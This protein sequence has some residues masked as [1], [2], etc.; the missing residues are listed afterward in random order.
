MRGRLMEA[1]ESWRVNERRRDAE[2]RLDRV[3]RSALELREDKEE[4]TDRLRAG[5]AITWVIVSAMALLA[6]QGDVEKLKDP[7]QLSARAPDRFRARFDTSQGVFVIAVEGVGTARRRPF[8]QSREERLLQRHAFLPGPR[9]LHGAVWPARRSGR[10]GSVEIRE[11]ERR[12]GGQEQH[13]RV[14]DLHDRVAPGLALHDDLHQLQGQQ[15]PGCRRLCALWAGR[16][17]HR[18]VDRLCRG[19]GRQTARISSAF[20]ERAMRICSP[21]TETGFCE[22]RDNRR[23]CSARR[24]TEAREPHA[25]G[26]ASSSGKSSTPRTNNSSGNAPRI[27]IEPFTTVFGTP[28]TRKRRERSRNSVAST[29]E[30]WIKAFSGASRCASDTARG[31][32][33]HVGVTKTWMSR[34]AVTYAAIS[35]RLPVSSCESFV[36]ARISA[37]MN[38][39]NSLSRQALPESAYACL[40]RPQQHDGWDVLHPVL[41]GPFAIEH[42]VDFFDRINR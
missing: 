1:W 13:A 41:G 17:R 29:H 14:R 6:A 5:A 39:M 26:G 34:G 35:A 9:R 10:A 36:P 7:A 11:L 27:S 4:M 33:G 3:L 42:E 12:A 25:L 8:L 15:L 2:E 18:I 16:E 22:D 23:E 30:A 20:C 37:S 24:R 40:R 19:Y 28:V 32:C 31:Q 38:D 21:S